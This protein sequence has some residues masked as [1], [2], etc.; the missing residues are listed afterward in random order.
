MYVDFCTP[1]NTIKNAYYLIY[2]DI[3]LLTNDMHHY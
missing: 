2:K 1:I 3:D